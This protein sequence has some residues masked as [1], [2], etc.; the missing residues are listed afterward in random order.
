VSS[1]QPYD[2]C[3]DVAKNGLQINTTPALPLRYR[4]Y[5]TMDVWKYRRC[6]TM[7]FE[8]HGPETCGLVP[9]IT[10]VIQSTHSGP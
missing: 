6:Y 4:K 2:P 10:F 5:L 1:L 7:F 3:C 8:R 9:G